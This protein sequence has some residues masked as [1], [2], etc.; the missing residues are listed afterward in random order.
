VH[1]VGMPFFGLEDAVI[2]NLFIVLQAL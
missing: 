2:E 1:D